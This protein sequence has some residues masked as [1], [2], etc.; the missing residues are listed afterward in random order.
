MQTELTFEQEDFILEDGLEKNKEQL[1]KQVRNHSYLV[2]MGK[3]DTDTQREIIES[4]I[5]DHP[6]GVTDTEL[7]ILTG[8]SKSSVTARRNEIEGV[9]PIG[10]AKYVD[11]DGMDRF[12]T[13]WGIKD[14]DI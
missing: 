10:I 12:N 7:C 6:E 4:I 5:E 13:L 1:S 11:C 9:I 14:N 2:T 8:I 3:P